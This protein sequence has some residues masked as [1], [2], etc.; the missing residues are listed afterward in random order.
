M[1]GGFIRVENVKSALTKKPHNNQIKWIQGFEKVR[2]AW[3]VM[4]YRPL[5]LLSP[6]PTHSICADTFHLA[7][8]FAQPKVLY[9]KSILLQNKL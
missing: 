2:L 3:K 4:Y 5:S 6:L 9:S 8:I 7:V 1:W